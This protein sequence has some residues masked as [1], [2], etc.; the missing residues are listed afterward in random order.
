MK[1]F[2]PSTMRPEPFDDFGKSR[3]AAFLL[4]S[5]KGPAGIAFPSFPA[6]GGRV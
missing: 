2:C 3:R 1:R 6:A 5:F 4:I